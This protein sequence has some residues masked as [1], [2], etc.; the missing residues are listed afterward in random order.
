MHYVSR[1]PSP[2]N[3]VENDK[4]K[5]KNLDAKLDVSINP[6]LA[7][8]NNTTG[9]SEACLDKISREHR[10]HKAVKSDNAQVPEYLWD[11]HLLEGCEGTNWNADVI[12]KVRTVTE[13]LR[14]RMLGW[15]KRKVTSSYSA[16]VKTKYG[17]K[18]QDLVSDCYTCD[19]TR[20]KNAVGKDSSM[21][22]QRRRA[23]W[24]TNDGGRNAS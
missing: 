12:G 1:N 16:W 11:S 21:V 10:Q 7:N 15:W 23:I 13:W 19:W 6:M 17:I 24:S 9:V 8:L 2:S 18:S 22:G 20:F 3:K 4:V 14:A 5:E